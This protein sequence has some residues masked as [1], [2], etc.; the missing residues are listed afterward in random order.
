MKSDPTPTESRK[1]EPSMDA[2]GIIFAVVGAASGIFTAV[3]LTS[4]LPLWASLLITFMIWFVVVAVSTASC[5]SDLLDIVVGSIT[6]IIVMTFVVAAGVRMWQRRHQQTPPAAATHA[7]HH[8]NAPSL[9]PPS[10]PRP[11][12]PST[13]GHCIQVPVKYPST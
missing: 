3:R 7:L 2:Q 6:I 12:P 4:V 11:T 1:P 13:W 8:S 9:R 10:F 5:G